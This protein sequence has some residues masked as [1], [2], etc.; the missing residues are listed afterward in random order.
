MPLLARALEEGKY[1][2]LVDPKLQNNYDHDEMARMVACAA[3][4][5]RHLARRR[6]RMSQVCSANDNGKLHC[7]VI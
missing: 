7:P 4:S 3:G 2:H 1:D 5:V 6:P